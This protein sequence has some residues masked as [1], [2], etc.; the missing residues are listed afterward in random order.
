MTRAETMA[1][2]ISKPYTKVNHKYFTHGEFAYIDDKG[3]FRDEEGYFLIW[4]EFWAIRQGT[5][6]ETDWT[7]VE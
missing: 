3:D 1:L 4:D 6:W 7:V 5:I 2:L